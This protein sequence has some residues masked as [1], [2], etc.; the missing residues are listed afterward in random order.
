M[1]TLNDYIALENDNRR[2]REALKVAR[3]KLVLYRQEHSG[4]YIGGVEYTQ[5]I[6]Q[7]D[8]ALN[9]QLGKPDAQR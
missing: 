9:Q 6:R 8:D 7:I 3:E 4:V 5:L 2:L 1:T